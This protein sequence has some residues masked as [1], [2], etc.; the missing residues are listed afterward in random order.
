MS[1]QPQPFTAVTASFYPWWLSYLWSLWKTRWTGTLMDRTSVR[2]SLVL[3][4][5]MWNGG[6]HN[7]ALGNALRV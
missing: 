2:G 6:G 1:K 4:I 5:V 3:I 7:A